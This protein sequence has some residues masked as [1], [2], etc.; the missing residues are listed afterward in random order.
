MKTCMQ[1]GDADAHIEWA[2]KVPGKEIEKG[3]V[4]EILHFFQ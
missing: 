3:H 2:C 1:A 4:M